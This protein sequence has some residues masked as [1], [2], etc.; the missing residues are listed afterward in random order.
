MTGLKPLVRRTTPLRRCDSRA[1]R[2]SCGGAAAVPRSLDD[3]AELADRIV[4]DEDRPDGA[5]SASRRRC[6]TDSAFSDLR[7]A[8]LTR[9]RTLMAQF[10]DIPGVRD[11]Q[12]AVHG[13]AHRC[14]RRDCRP[15]SSRL[16]D[17]VAV[18]SARTSTSTLSRAMP[19]RR[20]RRFASETGSQD[21]RCGWRAAALPRIVR[22][23]SSRAPAGL[24]RRV[25]A[26]DQR[27]TDA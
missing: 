7:W 6:S 1:C 2:R 18:A 16:A 20:S 10:F 25:P 13:S 14:P 5:W 23:P 4:L 11:A 9:W 8:R 27:L 24:A 3:L 22:W 12:R 19:S 21:W 15:A 26:A 17:V